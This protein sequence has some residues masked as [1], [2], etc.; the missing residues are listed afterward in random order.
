[1]SLNKRLKTIPRPPKQCWS[2][3]LRPVV[4]VTAMLLLSIIAGSLS[5]SLSPTLPTASAGGCGDSDGDGMPDD[6]EEDHAL[7]PDYPSDAW[8]DLDRDGY[9]NLAEYIHGTDPRNSTDFPDIA[10]ENDTDVDGVCNFGEYL[11]GTNWT[12]ALSV[13]G[14]NDTDGDGL[15]DA[16]ELGFGDRNSTNY[17]LEMDLNPCDPD[18]DHDGYQDDRVDND[19][20]PADGI[21]DADHTVGVDESWMDYDDDHFIEGFNDGVEV[22][23]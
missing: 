22:K 4:C 17:T 18:T 11:A 23:L 14:S 2:I 8:Y 20:N 6:W 9:R 16:F 3:Y 15:S 19:G 12:D 21:K 5:H 13:P 7:N 10:D 1:M